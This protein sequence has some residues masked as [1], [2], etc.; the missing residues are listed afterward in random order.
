MTTHAEPRCRNDAAVGGL[1]LFLTLW[2][3]WP[4]DDTLTTLAVPTVPMP[5]RIWVAGVI[6]PALLIAAA[7]YF[8]A[9]SMLWQVP[10]QALMLACLCVG[11]STLVLSG[12]QISST[13]ARI[14]VGY[15]FAAGILGWL[16]RDLQAHFLHPHKT[17]KPVPTIDPR[18]T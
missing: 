18:A 8:R 4:I 5:P 10:L 6:A 11:V 17:R 3:L 1:V 12:H 13:S 16:T 2:F 7:A 14:C 9:P 15:L